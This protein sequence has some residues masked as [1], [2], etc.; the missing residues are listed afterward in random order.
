MRYCRT[1]DIVDTRYII[2]QKPEN[3]LR[4]LKSNDIKVHKNIITIFN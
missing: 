3:Y 2:V 1:Y 4:S